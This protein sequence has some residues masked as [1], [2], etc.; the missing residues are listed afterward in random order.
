MFRSGKTACV[1]ACA[2][3]L[4]WEVFEVYPGIGKRNGAN[5]DNLIGEVGRNHLVRQIPRKRNELFVP[6]SP[7]TS[8][9][10]RNKDE[11]LLRRT[12]GSQTLSTNLRDILCQVDEEQAG[13]KTTVRQS[14]ILL[15]EVDILFKE[16][17]NFWPTLTRVIRECK[18]PV[19]CTC[20]DI[21]LVPLL[22]LP[23][24]KVLVFEPCPP[25]IAVSYL[26]GLFCAEGYAI[27][28]DV[29]LG[30]YGSVYEPAF[31]SIHNTSD[32][33]VTDVA[34]HDLRRTIHS[35]QVVATTR[36]LPPEVKPGVGEEEE[37][38]PE[39][40]EPGGMLA[41][42]R[43][44]ANHADHISFL[45]SF[46]SQESAKVL[47]ALDI[48]GSAPSADDELGHTILYESAGYTRGAG[49][50]GISNREKEMFSTATWLA[51]GMFADVKNRTHQERELLYARTRYQKNI[52]KVLKQFCLEGIYANGRR[53]LYT[54]Y[55]PWIR[56]M[57]TGEDEQERLFESRQR[58]GRLTRNSGGCYDRCVIVSED[59]REGLSSSVF[60]S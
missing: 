36:G 60:K 26:Q 20:N 7:I 43:A 39:A 57:V 27:N 56:A 19:V 44:A 55:G 33:G 10:N 32:I 13:D 11:S 4:G 42:Y 40:Y 1:Y 47:I 12:E 45:D 22:D 46:V 53:C 24:Q 58:S 6:P 52:G 5:V 35:L 25:P 38:S 9:G 8:S 29:L 37:P 31:V 34:T 15:E 18:R 59:A 51:H 21:S 30:M 48:A 17:T 50:V 23:L 49:D 16:D 41:T 54:E 14:L 28:R 3:E 2:E